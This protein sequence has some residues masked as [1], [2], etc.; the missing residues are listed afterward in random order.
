M[1]AVQRLVAFQGER[2]ANSEDAV[3][4]LFGEVGVLPCRT[5]RDVFEAVEEGR[6][7]E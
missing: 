6:A 7:T 4:R 5:L 3:I 1:M 2:G